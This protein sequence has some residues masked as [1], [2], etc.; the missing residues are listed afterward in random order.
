[1]NIKYINI[2]V[3]A[4]LLKMY[5]KYSYTINF[6]FRLTIVVKLKAYPNFFS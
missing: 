2:R 3:Y 1:M 5:T 6:T 4:Q